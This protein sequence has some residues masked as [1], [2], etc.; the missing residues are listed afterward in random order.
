MVSAGTN[1]SRV[2]RSLA[3]QERQTVSR[4]LR[5]SPR[6]SGLVAQPHPISDPSMQIP[7]AMQTKRRIV[8]LRENCNEPAEVDISMDSGLS[9]KSPALTKRQEPC[10]RR[11]GEHRV[12]QRRLDSERD[13]H[14]CAEQRQQQRGSE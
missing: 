6:S 1:F 12:V 10:C 7:A 3:N 9:I 5:I 4:T 8:F 11:R 13:R 14:G 2:F